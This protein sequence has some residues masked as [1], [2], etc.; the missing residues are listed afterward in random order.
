M[1]TF[2]S[3]M[4]YILNIMPFK[5]FVRLHGDQQYK[6][7]FVETPRKFIIPKLSIR[8]NERMKTQAYASKASINL[9]GVFTKLTYMKCRL[10]S[11][12]NLRIQFCKRFIILNRKILGL[13][14]QATVLKAVRTKISPNLQISK[15]WSDSYYVDV[16]FSDLSY[17]L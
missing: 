4:F 5:F 3:K 9:R 13:V 10:F 14:C 7:S 17:I 6:F 11:D 1:M 2:C 12:D 15:I 8:H 16:I